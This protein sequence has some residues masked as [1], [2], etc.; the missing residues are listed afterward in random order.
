MAIAIRW[1]DSVDQVPDEL[2]AACFPPPLEGRWW[3]E[4]LEKCGLEDQFSFAYALI[5]KDGSPVG[6]APAFVM[7]VPLDVIVPE[8]LASFVRTVG[9]YLRFVRYQ[10]TLFVGS[11]CSEEGTVGLIPGVGLV[12]VAVPLA[13]ALS[14]RARRAGAWM[15]VWKDFAEQDATALSGLDGFF[16]VVSYPGTKLALPPGGLDAYLA[17]LKSAHRNKLKK[18]LRVGPEALPTESSVAQHPDA[19]TLAE[20][21]ALFWQTYTKGKT[22]FERLNL[23][24]FERIAAA[25]TSHFVLLRK[26]ESRELV[27]FMLVFDCG[28]RLVN[29]FIGINYAIPDAYLYFQLWAAAVDWASLRGFTEIQSGQ[30]G[31]SAKLEIGNTLVPLVNFARHRN[32]LVHWIF[33]REAREISWATIDRDLAAHL[34]ARVLPESGGTVILPRRG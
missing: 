9:K 8:Q 21:F 4:A 32:P 13:H 30:T 33:A 1:L 28:P 7:D 24:F 25:P 11:P 3:Y 15:I 26:K 16:R 14:E 23:R 31:Y 2:W 6:L 18:K 5:E 27:A 12:E 20:I 29:K 10:R 34:A 22:K 19:A 17:T